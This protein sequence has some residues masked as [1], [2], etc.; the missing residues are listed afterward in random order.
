M[1]SVRR[2]GDE[3]I[4]GRTSE[5]ERPDKARRVE[6]EP[7]GQARRGTD[8]RTHRTVVIGGG[9]LG[10]VVAQQLVET[11]TDT[12][13]GVHYIDDDHLAVARAAPG[14]EATLVDDLTSGQAVE[15]VADGTTAVV[16]AAASDAA[17][18]LVVGQLTASFD[19]PRVVA[20]VRDARNRDAFP[21]TVDCVCTTTLLATAVVETLH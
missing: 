21:P 13:Q 1:S 11:G 7:R 6:T 14:H 18:L 8:E 10:R 20:V 19:I 17:T 16:I 12:E 3:L 15:S 4:G 5:R 9:Q 2:G